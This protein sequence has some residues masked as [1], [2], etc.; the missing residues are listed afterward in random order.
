MPVFLAGLG[1]DLVFGIVLFA[2]MIV[3]AI[4]LMRVSRRG[5]GRH[6]RYIRVIERFPLNR[7]SSIV[8]VSIGTRL[9][10]VCVGRDGGSLLCELEPGET[11]R[12]SDTAQTEP[13]TY[14]SQ[15]TQNAQ[16]A[17]GADADGRLTPRDRVNGAGKRFWHN[18]RI[19]LGLLPKGTPPMTPRPSRPAASKAD[20]KPQNNQADAMFAEVLNAA[21][22]K[23][24]N[25]GE[26]PPVQTGGNYAAALENMRRLAQ[27]ENRAAAPAV[28]ADPKPVYPANAGHVKDSD[29]ETARELLRMLQSRKSGNTG[30]AQSG[31]ADN[32]QPVK[33]NAGQ[34][35]QTEQTGQIDEMLDKIAKR[36]SRYSSKKNGRGNGVEGK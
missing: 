20:V 10:A 11:E 28:R 14:R 27:T 4:V 2:A 13:G 1:W 24:E 33:T 9:L 7:D 21:R 36:Q 30:S 18:M 12:H 35:G 5:F 6:S 22:Q 3:G 34:A 19:N 15:G 29:E 32:A 25:T 8:L 23:A 16:N 17:Q 31:S 26:S